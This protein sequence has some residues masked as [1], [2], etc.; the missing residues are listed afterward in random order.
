MLIKVLYKYIDFPPK[1]VL[2]YLQNKSILIQ[3]PSDAVV[4]GT[5]D[6]TFNTINIYFYNYNFELTVRIKKIDNTTYYWDHM[7]FVYT[8]NDTY[9][10]NAAQSTGEYTCV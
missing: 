2:V 9:F 7:T 3:V 6:N 10:V 1:H 8:I 5:C 4:N